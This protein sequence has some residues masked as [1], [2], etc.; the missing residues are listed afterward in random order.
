MGSQFSVAANKTLT[1]NSGAGLSISGPA[2]VF[3]DAAQ[4][5]AV[6]NLIVTIGAGAVLSDLTF[7]LPS[8][9]S[10][11]I[12]TTGGTIGITATAGRNLSYSTGASS[13]STLNLLGGAVTTTTTGVSTI[14]G[15]GVTLTADSNLTMNVNGGTFNDSGTINT[16]NGSTISILSTSSLTMTGTTPG[17]ISVTGGTPGQILVTAGSGGASNPLNVNTSFTFNPGSGG[18]FKMISAASTGSIS[19][20]NSTTQTIQGGGA[21]EFGTPSF[22]FGLSTAITATGDSTVT[23]NSGG[24]AKNMTLNGPSNSIA[25]VTTN[26]ISSAQII[27]Q[28]TAG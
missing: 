27:I 21:V 12:H 8:N 17:A 11:T 20:A 4:I 13:T 5:N 26:R 10:A 23:F 9:G 16:S 15:T 22:T 2:L 28:P 3:G 6:G 18:I 14:I 25:T 24:G 1:V 19:L 7:S